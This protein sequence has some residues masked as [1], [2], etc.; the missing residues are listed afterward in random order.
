MPVAHIAIAVAAMCVMAPALAGAQISVTTYH[1]DNLRT[2][3]N[4]GETTLTQTNLGTFGPVQRVTLDDQ[5]DAEPLIV[6]N[7]T[8]NGTR[9]NAVYV[10]TESNSVYAIDAESGQVLLKTNVGAPV[11]S[12]DLP[13]GCNNNG[14]NVGIDSTPVID[15]S[16]GALYVIAY[17]LQSGV[18]TYALHA[19]SL[20]TLADIVTP[21]TISASGRLNNGKEY[22]FNA[23]VSRQRAALLLANGT[24]YAGFGSF[25]DTSAN[26]SRG[27]V[28]GWQEN[29]LAPLASNKLTNARSG[30]PNR[31]FLTSVW[32][33]GYGPAADAHGSVYF[34]TGNS[35]YSGTTFN[36]KTNI[37]ESA[38]K[39]SADLS[40]LESLFTPGNH[41]ALDRSDDEFGAGG[42]MLL[43]AQ[44]GLY[45]R[46]AAAA[47]KDGR[48][49]L[50]DSD[51]LDRTFGVYQIGRCWCG[52][53]YYRSGDGVGR[54]VTS[55]GTTV[56]VFEVHTSSKKK[57]VL[58]EQSQFA[59][60]AD[61]QNPG[62]FTSVSSNGNT[63]GTA[64]VWAVGR[65][66]N[67]DPAYVDLYAINPDNGE[68][69]FSGVA[70]Q[71]LNTTG[72]SNIV[73]MVA[74][75]RVYVASD[76]MLTIFALGGITKTVAL[77]AIDPSEL[78]FPLA[79]GEHEIYGIVQAIE[80]EFV[81]I[82]SRKG[83]LVRID[84]GRARRAS[85][86]ARP[87]LGHALLARGRFPGGDA[88]FLADTVQHAVDHPVMWPAD[89]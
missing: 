15:G 77:P 71:W 22:R 68:E 59:G 74:N 82:R 53:S 61:G 33:S 8:I 85:R 36:R 47:G 14:P 75:G 51:A 30:A 80:R 24:V 26:L 3:W 40:T 88:P 72:D 58:A 16:T 9:H 67:N 57:P 32:M 21:L 41:R 86:F 1:N 44:P 38:V 50:L 70:G 7:Q 18:Q 35:D 31:I 76:K 19:L 83:N 60:I 6:G 66:T 12:Y 28:L 39:M 10:A 69:L 20:A 79:H 73:P 25:C 89:R 4:P 48:L 2:G 34:V 62:F 5:V 42:L 23:A 43:P 55:G 56:E 64:L 87:S 63:R 13:G 84:T 65:P 54:I 52:P 37:A 78:R 81:T 17:V 46:L 11:P 45:P 49:Y 29:T 27:W